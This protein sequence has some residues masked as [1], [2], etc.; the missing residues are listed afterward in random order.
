MDGHSEA[1]A[2]TSQLDNQQH[3][4]CIAGKSIIVIKTWTHFTVC[5]IQL[6]NGKCHA[7]LWPTSEWQQLILISLACWHAGQQCVR[8]TQ[9]GLL[10]R[11]TAIT[12]HSCQHAAQLAVPQVIHEL[13]IS[14]YFSTLRRHSTQNCSGIQE[15]KSTLTSKLKKGSER[16][17]EMW[18]RKSRLG[19]SFGT[20]MQIYRHKVKLKKMSIHTASRIQLRLGL[21]GLGLG[22][23]FRVRVRVS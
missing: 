5:R 11:L 16:A 1:R 3:Y 21:V 20:A 9:V 6:C 12:P 8:W 18:P 17:T 4:G 15:Y 13:E 19:T 14:K 22:L 2:T 7:W 23:G 10:M